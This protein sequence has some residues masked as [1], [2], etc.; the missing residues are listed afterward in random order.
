VN[1]VLAPVLRFDLDLVLELDLG[2]ALVLESDLGIALVPELDLGIALPFFPLPLI[3][4]IFPTTSTYKIKFLLLYNER[5]R[6]V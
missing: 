6:I 5:E 1:A 4:L 2:T 3:N